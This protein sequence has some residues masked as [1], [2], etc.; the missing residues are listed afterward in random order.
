MKTIF[1]SASIP[2][3]KRN[4]RFF[5]TADVVAIGDVV[6]ALCSVALGGPGP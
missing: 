1:L 4:P 5:E 3:P 2:D 6:H